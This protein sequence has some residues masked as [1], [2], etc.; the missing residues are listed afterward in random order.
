M[1]V[2]LVEYFNHLRYKG[3]VSD[4]FVTLFDATK[5]FETCALS[6]TN[7]VRLFGFVCFV[8]TVDGL[9]LE[10]TSRAYLSPFICRT[11]CNSKFIEF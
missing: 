4:V 6:A 2:N 8:H 1:L 9:E 10:C 7:G 5:A 3:S 11:I